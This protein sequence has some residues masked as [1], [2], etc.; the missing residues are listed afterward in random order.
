M[1]CQDRTPLRRIRR[2]IPRRRRPCVLRVP[3]AHEDDAER[4][5]RAGLDLFA[6]VTAFKS[7]VTLQTRVD[8]ATGLV[9]VGDL[10]K[11]EDSLKRRDDMLGAI[12]G[13][14]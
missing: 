4:A 2:Q 6:A 9:V 3:Q 12:P 10:I 7:P 8:I 1:R 11:P 13:R 5:V 14:F